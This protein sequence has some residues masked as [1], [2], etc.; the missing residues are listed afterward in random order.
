MEFCHYDAAHKDY[1]F[2]EQWVTFLIEEMKKPGQYQKVLDA[3]A[4]TAGVRGKALA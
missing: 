1:V 4:T 3:K 2:T